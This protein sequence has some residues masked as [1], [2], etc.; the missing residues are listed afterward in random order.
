[1]VCWIRIRR[2]GVS[3]Q[4]MCTKAGSTQLTTHRSYAGS[5]GLQALVGRT[6]LGALSELAEEAEGLDVAEGDAAVAILVR[7]AAARTWE[8]KAG[9]AGF[10]MSLSA[11]KVCLTRMATTATSVFFPSPV[12]KNQAICLWQMRITAKET[13]TYVNVPLN[14]HAMLWWITAPMWMYG[15]T[16]ID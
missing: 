4:K 10:S 3:C 14:V 11:L 9:A 15:F 16:P 13:R 8:A 5:M 2:Q 7:I 1:M 12:H 6:T